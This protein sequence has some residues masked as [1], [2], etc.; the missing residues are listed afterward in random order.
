LCA[1]PADQNDQA[2]VWRLLCE[3]QEV[4]SVTSYHHAPILLSGGEDE[5]VSGISWQHVCHP[6]DFVAV[7]RKGI[8][9][10]GGNVVVEEKLHFSAWS[11]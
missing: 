1:A 5:L 8:F 2:I 9:D 3:R 10:R 4:V 7:P 6:Y 11:I